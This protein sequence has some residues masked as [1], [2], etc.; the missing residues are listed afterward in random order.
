MTTSTKKVKLVGRKAK[1]LNDPYYPYY[2]LYKGVKEP[3]EM[4]DKG[5]RKIRKITRTKSLK[6]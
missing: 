6:K 5:S 1:W 4:F 2:F 3:R